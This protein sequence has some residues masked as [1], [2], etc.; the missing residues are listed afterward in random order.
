MS[1]L[2]LTKHQMLLLSKSV[3]RHHPHHIHAVNRN[4]K[5]I[6]IGSEKQL[7]D[8]VPKHDQHIQELIVRKDVVYEWLR[9]LKALNPE[10]RDII[11][12]ES[13]EIR[14]ELDL[15][16]S[17]LLNDTI[18]ISSEQEINMEKLIQSAR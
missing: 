17:R 12:N 6:F 4:V 3:Q 13:D 18:I 2:S 9:A 10:Y 11:I 1:S 7:K 14:N 5:V 16:S 15:I 8:F